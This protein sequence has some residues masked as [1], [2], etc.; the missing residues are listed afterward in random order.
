LGIALGIGYFTQ[1]SFVLL[2]FI[3]YAYLLLNKE[4]RYLFQKKEIYLSGVIMLLII[5]L[6]LYWNNL[7]GVWHYM[8]LNESYANIKLSWT[9]LNFFLI[10]PI[11]FLRH[12][13]WRLLISWEHPIIRW[14]S[15]LII[16]SGALYSFRYRKNQYVNLLL[17][18]FFFMIC[19]FFF[20]PKGE[21]WWANISFIPGIILGAIMLNDLFEWRKGGKIFAV[22][23][24]VFLIYK[25]FII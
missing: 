18:V 14:Y 15:E 4:Y 23:I 13:D 5:G 25:S 16:V 24:M 11:A 7:S 8:F 21:F 6:D 22:L 3:L 10:E 17:W 20:F 2:P 12:I 1:L 19:I 9:G